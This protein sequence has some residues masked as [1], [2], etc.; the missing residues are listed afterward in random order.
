MET[1]Y[2]LDDVCESVF[3]NKKI[4][5]EKKDDENKDDNPF[6][7]T[8]DDDSSDASDTSDTSNDSSDD[9]TNDTDDSLDDTSSNE[10]SESSSD[11]MFSADDGAD[12][13]SDDDS[14][15]D[16]D[17]SD[18][19]SGAEDTIGTGDS[20][21]DEEYADVMNFGITLIMLSAQVHFWHINCHK[22]FEHETLQSLY[23]SLDSNGDK[24]LEN[25]VS[26]TH[27]S[28]LAGNE[29]NFDF[30]N[31]EYD[32]EESVG[33]LEDIRAEASDLA[34]RFQDNQGLCG[35][36]GDISEFIGTAIYK[37]TQFDGSNE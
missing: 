28:I 36:L 29:L 7:D 30:G 22:G 27:Q 12:D 6:A 17:D 32:K 8:K 19:D 37:L 21:Q 2:D 16:S 20:V 5:T 35:I 34:T 14:D 4:L 1:V 25:V 23:E 15:D 3:L 10:D 26:V 33:I 18:I 9:T 31:L 24:L 13:N 11:N